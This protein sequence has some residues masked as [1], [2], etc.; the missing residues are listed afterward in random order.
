M[1]AVLEGAK[2]SVQIV[3]ADFQRLAV[4]RDLAGKC[5]AEKLVADAHV[6][7]QHLP[8]AFLAAAADLQHLAERDEFRIALDVGHEVEH[9]FGGVRHAPRRPELRH[10]SR[11]SA[12][13][14]PRRPEPG[15]VLAGMMR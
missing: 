4:K 10:Q 8:L 1:P 9:R 3:G 15:E 11:W 14:E 12:A 2:R 7:N 13:R 6:G 5:L